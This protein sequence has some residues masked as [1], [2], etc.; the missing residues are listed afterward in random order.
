MSEQDGWRRVL[1]AFEEWIYYESTE[2]GPYTGYFSLDN[3]RDLTSKERISWMQSMYDEIIPGRV[4]R[5][6]YAGVAFE[7]FLPYMPDSTAR[8]VVQSMIDITQVLKDEM[9][10]MSDTIHSMKEEYESGGFEEIVPFLTN[11]ADAEESIR[12]HMSLFSQGFSK[13]RRM[14][15]EM[16][17]LE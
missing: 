15:L 7:D 13:L 17:D 10:A 6:R 1:D 11:L 5:C 4:D 12:H 3:L 2:F 14:G 8:E 16:P 9:L